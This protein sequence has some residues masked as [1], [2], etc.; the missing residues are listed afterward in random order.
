VLLQISARTNYSHP[1]VIFRSVSSILHRN[2][3]KMA[4]VATAGVAEASDWSGT[5]KTGDFQ[6]FEL[7]LKAEGFAVHPIL[8]VV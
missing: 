8:Y 4:A 2:D 1:L 5:V 3:G 6:D 7:A